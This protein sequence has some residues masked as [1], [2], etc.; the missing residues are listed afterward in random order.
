MCVIEIL[1]TLQFVLVP[2]LRGAVWI[3]KRGAVWTRLRFVPPS[4]ASYFHKVMQ[5][6]FVEHSAPGSTD[7]SAVT[8][9]FSLPHYTLTS[10]H[11]SPLYF[12][13]LSRVRVRGTLLKQEEQEEED[14][15]RVLGTNSAPIAC[16]VNIG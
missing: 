11:P 16:N 2:G 6:V 3:I 10:P 12:T 1:I 7:V 13:F 15:S 4:C 5:L 14:G 8:P 9:C